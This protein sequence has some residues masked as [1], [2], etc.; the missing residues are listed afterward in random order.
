[1][2]KKFPS[3][4]ARKNLTLC[5]ACGK[6]FPRKLKKTQV[7]TVEEEPVYK[8]YLECPHCKTIFTAFFEDSLSRKTASELRKLREGTKHVMP[9]MLEEELLKIDKLGKEHSLY[10][11]FLAKKYK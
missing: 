10:L 6:K 1:M 7:D 9:D 3:R 11:N 5:D 4:R 8:F 2:A